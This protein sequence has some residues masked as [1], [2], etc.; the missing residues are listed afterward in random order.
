MGTKRSRRFFLIA[1][2]VFT[3][4]LSGALPEAFV[5]AQEQ[6]KAAKDQVNA[7]PDS[8]RFAFEVVSIRLHKPG[9]PYLPRQLTADSYR[10][11]MSTSDMI[12]LAYSPLTLRYAAWSRIVNA[13]AWIHEMYDID[14]RIA[15]K[16]RDAWQHALLNDQMFKD[17]RF[18]RNALRA[19]LE[20]EF[21]L[22]IQVTPIMVPYFNL[23]VDKHGAKLKDT[24]SGSKAPLPIRRRKL[25]DGYYFDENGERRFVGVWMPDFA[26]WLTS[27]TTDLPIQD[28]TG[29]T[30]RYDF[31]LPINDDRNY[32]ESEMRN[33]VAELSLK[34]IGLTLKKGA[35]PAFNFTIE[36]IQ[37]PDEN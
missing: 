16:D 31:T 6:G 18:E 5:S 12:N 7:T 36:H 32:P 11:S 3:A 27:I 1:L 28:M 26:A 17:D 14:A 19:V 37:R 35:G 34:S 22:K 29:F 33:P 8:E 2:S 30:G 25:G 24:V 20:E 4:Y 10:S 13:P 9:T 15:E 21:K 23:T